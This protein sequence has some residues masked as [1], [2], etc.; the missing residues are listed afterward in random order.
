MNSLWAKD[1][2]S[3]SVMYTVEIMA[4]AEVEAHG[5]RVLKLG[6]CSERYAQALTTPTSRPGSQGALYAKRKG[7]RPE[8][9]PEK[10][11]EV[12]AMS[13]CKPGQLR[14]GCLPKGTVCAVQ[15]KQTRKGR[16]PE[17]V[18]YGHVRIVHVDQFP[19]SDYPKKPVAGKKRRG[20]RQRAADKLKRK[21]CWSPGSAAGPAHVCM[22]I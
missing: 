15:A 11:V 7:V 2:A 20:P 6:L 3:G 10:P 22:H 21:R 13:H 14:V 5:G 18:T 9:V 1:D 12:R 4:P 19:F 17:T 16:K 8:R